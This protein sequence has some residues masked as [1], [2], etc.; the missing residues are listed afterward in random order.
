MSFTPFTF[1]HGS[2]RYLQELC[3]FLQFSLYSQPWF[4][5]CYGNTRISM[6]GFNSHTF[7]RS[8]SPT[9]FSPS[10]RFSLPTTLIHIH[11]R[12]NFLVSEA[13]FTL[14]RIIYYSTYLHV[15][16][17]GSSESRKIDLK[18]F[19]S[20]FDRICYPFFLPVGIF[21]A[22]F[23]EFRLVVD[24]QVRWAVNGIVWYYEY[25]VQ[26][27][28]HARPEQRFRGCRLGL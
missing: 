8:S 27:C 6:D 11:K 18:H 21:L 14:T 20:I 12:A 7:C 15:I 10:S 24:F 9:P 13:T 22:H 2:T 25:R 26:G 28:Y 23:H 19:S 4:I 17:D 5:C 3:S 1:S 16:V